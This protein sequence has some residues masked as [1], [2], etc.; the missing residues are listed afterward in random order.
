MQRFSDPKTKKKTVWG[1]ISRVLQQNNYDFDGSKCERKLINMKSKYKLVKVHNRKSGNDPKTCSFYDELEDI[2]GK[3]PAICPVATC[4][5]L[6]G[7]QQTAEKEVTNVAPPR[8][9]S[10]ES[11][12]EKK[13]GKKPHKKMKTGDK[14]LQAFVDFSK[15]QEEREDKRMKELVNMHTEQMEATNKF[16]GVFEKFLESK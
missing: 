3:S 10:D 16:I 12:E 15:S 7:I 9:E 13:M 5:S 8:T 4:S 1:D 11:T 2:F 14:L 6:N